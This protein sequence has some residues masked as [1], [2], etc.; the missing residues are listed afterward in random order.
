M[1][2]GQVW[3]PFDPWKVVE[4]LRR[5]RYEMNLRPTRERIVSR[6]L[7]RKAYYYVRELLPVAARLPAEP[8]IA[9]GGSRQPDPI[10]RDPVQLFRLARLQ[11]V[12]DKQQIGGV[13]E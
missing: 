11:V 8:V 7:V 13:A 2:E 1:E 9:G 6:E 12:P 5:E 10:R 3:V 4:N